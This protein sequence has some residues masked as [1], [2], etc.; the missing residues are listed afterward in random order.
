VNLRK[1]LWQQTGRVL[2]GCNLS[3]R[4]AFT[5]LGEVAVLMVSQK[6]L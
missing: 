5:G 1:G 6:S 2:G 4:S 3:Q